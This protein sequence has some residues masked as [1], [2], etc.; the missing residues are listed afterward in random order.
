MKNFPKIIK[1]PL[2]LFA[3]ALTLAPS[4]SASAVSAEES[5]GSGGLVDEG[6]DG[7]APNSDATDNSKNGGYNYL[8]DG[9]WLY[10]DKGDYITV[11]GYEG[12]AAHITI[13]EEI[14]GKKVTTVKNHTEKLEFEGMEGMEATL[15][16]DRTNKNTVWVTIPEGVIGIG[17]ETFAY[18]AIERVELP[19]SLEYIGEKAFMDCKGLKSIEIPKN[20][21]VIDSC[22]FENSA[23]EE[24]TLNEGLEY[25]GAS[26]FEKTVNLRHI[27]IPDSV[28]DIGELA[29]RE[30]GIE[31][32]TL[33]SKLSTVRTSLF[34]FCLNLKTAYLSEGIVRLESDVF[35]G[36]RNLESVY[37]PSTLTD[38]QGVFTL[39]DSLR[40]IYVAM[41]EEEIEFLWGNDALDVLTCQ[42]YDIDEDNG[43]VRIIPDTAVPSRKAAE[44]KRN[45]IFILF[46]GAIILAFSAGAVILAVKLKKEKQKAAAPKEEKTEQIF[47][48]ALGE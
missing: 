48:G 2:L 9:E 33:P 26:A 16:F 20:V 17:T 45:L 44:A 15:F 24:I 12:N 29:F 13:P 6:G 41:S 1:A 11:C 27:L 22:A 4:V 19:Q 3:F 25:I 18:A 42:N 23:I 7:N 38:I 39:F 14:N 46:F 37:L 34:N 40:N 28:E 8:S 36:C 43:N 21:K 47:G 35:Y 32:I 30:S 5:G 31:E 10:W